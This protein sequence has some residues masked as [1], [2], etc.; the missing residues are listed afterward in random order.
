MQRTFV[1]FI[2]SAV[3]IPAASLWAASPAVSNSNPFA[4]QIADQAYRVQC[5]ADNLQGYILSGADGR[6][7]YVYARD[8]QTSA[9]KLAS[10]V[11]KA[12]TQPGIAGEARAQAEKMKVEAA[13]LNAMVAGTVS[14]LKPG[15]FAA[16]TDA[17]VADTTNIE[18]RSNTLRNA[19]QTLN[20]SN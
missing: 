14:E 8:M 15:R 1:C 13:G 4:S 12:A 6:S 2:L 5:A 16:N 7:A 18:N 20:G 17:I 11:D 3:S 9:K 10:L 19:A